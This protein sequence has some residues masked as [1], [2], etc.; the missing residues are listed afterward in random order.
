MQQLY[1]IISLIIHPFL[2]FALKVRVLKKKEHQQRFKEKLGYSSI[3]KK[4]NII[5]FHVSSLGEIKSIHSLIKYYQKKPELNLLITSVTLSSYEYF[6]KN[7]ENK[8]TFHQFAPLDTSIIV[9]R[10]LKH[11]EPKLSIFVESELWPNMIFQSS[12]NSKLILLNCRISK[13]S[14]EK[15]KFFE[16]FFFKIINTFEVVLPQSYEVKK[17]LDYFNLKNIKYIGNLKFTNLKKRNPNI[18]RIE[19]NTNS[20]AA[21]SIHSD[22][23]DQI[24][25]VHL[26]LGE[27]INTLTSFLIPRHLD[28]IDH[29]IKI[30]KNKN[31]KYQRISENNY[32]K[33]FNGIVVV[34]KFGI[35]EDIFNSVNTVFLGGS[36]INHGGQNPMEPILYNCKV[37]TGNNYFNFTEIYD[38]LVKRKLATV[39]R[40]KKELI[41]DLSTQLIKVEEKSQNLLFQEFSGDILKDTVK[42]IDSYIY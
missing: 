7:F 11:W 38:D 16:K 30:I 40:D 15:W 22:E 29:I 41:E 26:E 6:K 23:M 28:K 24:I 4:K 17:I 32:V 33:K 2:Y 19:K 31:I 39:V 20:W 5:W 42:L 10:F 36:L 37:I 14:F 34:D 18:I 35:A 21:M 13:K 25:D 3:E 27:K 1:S 8:N 9:N 12:K